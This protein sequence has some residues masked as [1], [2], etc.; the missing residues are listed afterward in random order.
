MSEEPGERRSL[1][2]L[3]RRALSRLS[4]SSGRLAER[5]DPFAAFQTLYELA[6]SPA[7]APRALALLH[8]LQVHQVELDLQDEELRRSR[9]E[10]ESALERQIQ[11]YDGAPV[12]Y[13]TVD[14]QLMI[15]EL[16]QT[17]AD[18]LGFAREAILGLAFDGFLTPDSGRDLRG[19][20]A[21]LTN[22]VAGETCVLEMTSRRVHASVSRDPAGQQFLIVLM[23][24]RTAAGSRVD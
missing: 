9:S 13:F 8:E 20:L 15:S 12:G 24:A 4:G 23:D 16:N 17:G 6:S 19:R 3:R 21:R 22:G 5:A 1:S 14:R 11:L 7:T 18:M 10:I 2:D